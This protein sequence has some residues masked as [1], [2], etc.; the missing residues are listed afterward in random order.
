MANQLKRTPLYQAHIE[1]GARMI[2]FGGWEMPVQYTSLIA[3]H[4]TV[5]EHAGIFDLSHM[6]EFYFSGPGAESNLQRLLS[7]DVSALSPGQAQYT[8][9]L[10]EQGGIVDDVIVYR[11]EDGRF[12]L[13]ANAA[14][15]DK[16]RV[17]IEAR[18]QGDVAFEDKSAKTAL[19]AV[20]GPKA[21]EILA[22]LASDDVHALPSFHAAQTSVGGVNV[23][24]SRTGY[25]GEDGFELYC[26]AADAEKLWT[27]LM[28]AGAPHGMVPVGL[29]ARDTLRL[30]ARLP[31]YGNDLSDETSPLEAGLSF[32]VKLDKGDF[33][34]RDAL[35]A[36]KS[37]GPKKRLVGFVMEGRGGAPRHGY[38]ILYECRQVGEVT[39]GTFSPTLEKEIGLGY[40][41]TA[42]AAPGTSI[43]IE[44]RKKAR[45]AEVVKGRFVTGNAKKA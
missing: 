33:I 43:D 11:L 24:L 15:T 35:L 18:L 19:L 12:L 9:I 14:N 17:W 21:V 4:R 42:L 3:E 1:L 7:N 8:L 45:R 40:V 26:D 36:Q 32:A 37:E 34:G 28:E 16:D 31:L 29:G 22:P 6:G 23:L 44:V 5:R 30:E 38:P 13:V 25:T 41:E 2:E 39:S 27:T 20:Q 10:N